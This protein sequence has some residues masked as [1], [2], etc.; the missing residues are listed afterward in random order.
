MRLF[1]SQALFTL[2]WLAASAVSRGDSPPRIEE[3]EFGKMPDG[4]PVKLFTL[5]NAK[6]VA[7]KVMAYGAT[8]TELQV[9]DRRGALTPAGA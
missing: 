2:V 4:A 3:R 9:P 6:G 8:L 7:A 1:T 5:R